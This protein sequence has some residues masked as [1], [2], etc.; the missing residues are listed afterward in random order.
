MVIPFPTNTHRERTFFTI[1]HIIWS[2]WGWYVLVILP[3]QAAPGENKSWLR[4]EEEI[5]KGTAFPSG[6]YVVECPM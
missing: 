3:E 6:E 2:A 1:E 5:W 4:N